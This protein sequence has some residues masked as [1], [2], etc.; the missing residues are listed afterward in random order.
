MTSN[1]LASGVDVFVLCERQFADG[2]EALRRFEVGNGRA[3]LAVK[4]LKSELMLPHV[5][6]DPGIVA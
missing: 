3:V 1:E 5:L 6:S 4:G 2:A